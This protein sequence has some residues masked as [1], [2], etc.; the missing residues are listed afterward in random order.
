MTSRVE[1]LFDFPTVKGL[2]AAR[3]CHRRARPAFTLLTIESSAA[4]QLA[5]APTI[6]W[7]IALIQNF[8]A[9]V[10]PR[11]CAL[12]RRLQAECHRRSFSMAQPLATY[13]VEPLLRAQPR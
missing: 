10:Y 1:P 3:R 7:Y 4:A 8:W 12:P 2:H 6:P 5:D 9:E 11:W 13:A